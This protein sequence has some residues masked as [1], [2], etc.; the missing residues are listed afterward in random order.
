M[1]RRRLI[2]AG[3]ALA[4]YAG[5]AQAAPKKPSGTAPQAD[6]YLLRGFGDIFSTGIDEIGRQLQANGV[7]AHV[8]GH[9]AWRFVLNR[10]LADQRENP[11]APVV[12]IG[13]SLGANAVIDI[14]AALEKKGISVAYMATF[15][16]TAPAPLP[17]NIKRVVNFYFKQHGWGLP[18]TAGPR[19]RGSLDNRDFSGMRDIGHFNIEKQRPLQ[20]E[21]VRN[22]LSI[23]R[24]R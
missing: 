8:E 10:I 3:A 9:Q 21:V 2:F 12:L 4:L 13:H 23:V 1:T 16:A 5:A 11:R 18:L 15:A 20:D 14:A 6:V 19:F 24:S 7:D 22:V 17:G